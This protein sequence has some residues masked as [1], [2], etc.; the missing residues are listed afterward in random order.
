MVRYL[1]ADAGNDNV[2]G[3]L[4]PFSITRSR[5]DLVVLVLLAY[6]TEILP[7]DLA[8]I[9]TSKRGSSLFYVD[10]FVNLMFAID[11]LINFNTGY[12]DKSILVMQPPSAVRRRYLRTWFIPDFMAT[13]PFDLILHSISSG[14][15]AKIAGRSLRC[16]RIL[17]FLRLN[18]IVRLLRRKT[19][20]KQAHQ[21]LV[22]F[23]VTSFALAH[24]RPRAEYIARAH[25]THTHMSTHSAVGAVS[26]GVRVRLGRFQPQAWNHMED[27]AGRSRHTNGQLYRRNVLGTCN[28]V[29]NWLWRHRS[30]ECV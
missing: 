10:Q 17:R 26:A 13:V 4:H 18:R 20:M 19:N 30:D 28:D 21:M 11:I 8:Q 1:N 3:I 24:V 9:I 5:Y 2:G 22:I 29:H 27:F 6:T 12:F 14:S 7:L 23:V 15:G 25:G 16:L